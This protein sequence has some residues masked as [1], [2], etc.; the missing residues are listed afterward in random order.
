MTS[1]RFTCD[2]LDRP[3]LAEYGIDERD[4]PFTMD[5]AGN[6][7]SVNV[8]DGDNVDDAIDNLTNRYDSGGEKMTE[9]AIRLLKELA[10]S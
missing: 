9:T 6:G 8:R 4:G 2:G 10:Q 7:N 5:D 3:T 1:G